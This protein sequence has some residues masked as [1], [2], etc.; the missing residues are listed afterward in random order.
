MLDEIHPTLPKPKKSKDDNTYTLGSIG[1]HY[2]VIACLPKGRTGTASAANVAIK[3]INTF[4]NVRF[5]LMVGIGSGI[6]TGKV[7]VRLG[8]IV[9]S[10]PTEETPGVVQW[11]TENGKPQRTGALNNPPSLLLTALTKLETDHQL[12]GP[13]IPEYLGQLED[14]Y[15]RLASRYLRSDS[16][17][18]ILFKPDYHHAR[19]PAESERAKENEDEDNDDDDEY[20]DED[21]EDDDD[22]DMAGIEE[23]V[24]KVSLML[25]KKEDHKILEWL[26]TDYAPQQS[27]YLK[28][29]HTG[30]GQR[31]L[32]AH[33]FQNWLKDDNKIFF[34]SGIPGAGKTITTAIVIE[35]LNTVVRQRNDKIGIAY[36]YY[37]FK[38]S[39]EQDIDHA[40]ASLLRQLT[41]SLP[42]RSIPKG[43]IKLHAKHERGRTRPT[44]SEII[45][46]MTLVI[47]AY[48]KVFIVVDALDESPEFYQ[49]QFHQEI[50]NFQANTSKVNYFATSR[51][52][53]AITARF[54]NHQIWDIRASDIDLRLYLENQCKFVPGIVAEESKLH[55][56]IVKQIVKSADGMFL[57]A[58]LRLES[59][60]GMASQKEVFESLKR[61][62]NTLTDAETAY[63]SAYEDTMN[64][65]QSQVLPARKRALQVLSWI[66]FARRPLTTLEL[67]HALAIEPN[68][69]FLD[70]N[71][72]PM[73][74]L[75]V[76][77]C[78]GLVAI[79]EKSDV[80]RLVHYT[81]EEYFKRSR[82]GW[83]G[84]AQ[85][86]ITEKCVTYLL[87]E[88]FR[89]VPAVQFKGLK[90]K[91]H[92]NPFYDYA[93]NNWGYH[94]SESSIEQSQLVQNFL[95][96]KAA[97]LSCADIMDMYHDSSDKLIA[98]EA[99]GIHIA[100]FFGLS[101][102]LLTLLKYEPD[103]EAEDC[104]SR[105]PL[106]VAAGRGSELVA[107]LL[108]E[109]G[110]NVEG[111]NHENK[112][113]ALLW[114]VLNGHESI[115]ELLLEKGAN[116]EACN[117][118]ANTPPLIYAVITGVESMV[119][120]LLEQGAYLETK[121]GIHRTALLWAA[122]IG[123]LPITKLL[124]EQGADL[125]AKDIWHGTPLM[126]ATKERRATIVELLLEKGANLSVIDDEGQTPLM[127]A[128]KQ[129]NKSIIKLLLQ[130]SAA[131]EAGG[132]RYSQALVLWTR[133]NGHE[134]VVKLLL[135][136]VTD[137]E[138]RDEGLGRTPILW[139]IAHGNESVVKLLL[140]NGA[141]LEK[142]DRNGA[143][144]LTLAVSGGY[145]SLVELLLE[146]C[147]DL[148]KGSYYPDLLSQ[149][150]QNGHEAL[151][152]LFLE[153]GANIEG[154]GTR[155]APL[156]LATVYGHEGVVKLLL[157]R[158]AN[159]EGGGSAWTPLEWAAE[160]GQETIV[161]L[162]L[163]KDANPEAKSGGGGRTPLWRAA[164][165]GYEAIVKLLLEKG[166]DLEAKDDHYGLTPVVWAAKCGNQ[167][168]VALL[169]AN[170]A[171]ENPK[172]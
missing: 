164:G 59:L 7:K 98:T 18:D 108:L 142:R 147:A 25:E 65:I 23:K 92:L 96:S 85:N 112:D 1:E 119:R 156:L 145:K 2:V 133:R 122:S 78:C 111:R 103:I 11:K 68:T 10:V 138:D 45:E 70:K 160:K 62:Q 5:G 77:S 159:V 26:G 150:A 118:S 136:K 151:V 82:S 134:S 170:G 80:V 72:L 35:Y 172:A 132:Y 29:R 130:N 58:K 137:L 24:E 109:K 14:K 117:T 33:E 16:L 53:P 22:D 140:E 38:R 144:P 6:P 97:V 129:R 48:S 120:L 71:N 43:V 83:L 125:E 115:V 8:D 158:G 149:A 75:V 89:K 20:K 101:K 168:I 47:T 63:D 167:A 40:F 107:R 95:L 55:R 66:I 32:D 153:K 106:T 90:H 13:K 19:N 30:T 124:L 165:L 51:Y 126:V 166:V 162:L 143:T 148:D 139:A 3:M 61:N 34:C 9:V 42:S 102:A 15:P 171:D 155:S 27:D 4:P 163:E 46:T 157:E 128:V 17:Q 69:E 37:N 135:E 152:K 123:N 74:S 21:D 56:D 57:L 81:T 114:A 141:D 93:A 169:L 131:L 84:D 113:T 50:L 64:R 86:D 127:I 54:R 87:Y 104:R 49:P 28:L 44:L 12:N 110:A 99:T 73:K 154:D 91:L 41:Q 76:G 39:S 31:I 60:A 100:A 146:K 88:T 94:A 105:V 79:D 161:K 116:I 52:I 36:I 121:D 67:Q